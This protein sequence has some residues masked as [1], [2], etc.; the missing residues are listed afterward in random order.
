[1]IGRGTLGRRILA[2][3]GSVA[4]LAGLS[5]FVLTRPVATRQGVNYEVSEH[6]V[7][8]YLK[9]TDFMNRS[10]QYRQIA[11]E[12]AGAL[13]SDES[14][15][16]AVFEW[17]RRNVRPTP[18]GFPVVDDH[19]LN[20]VT[21]GYGMPDQRADVFATLATYAGVPAFWQTLRLSASDGGL[22]LTFVLIDGRWRV[23]DVGAGLA[24]RNERN[25]LATLDD[26]RRQ[27]ECVPA[28]LRDVVIGTI[29][30]GDRLARA[31]M[32][33][34]PDPLRAELQMPVVRLWHEMKVALHLERDEDAE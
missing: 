27:P 13:P 11:E 12:V 23:F 20:I 6:R 30:Y 9:A 3:R 28:S 31:T 21:R 26:L 25:E 17:T 14:R 24:F 8:L 16:L 19:I 18:D 4:A 29:T 33:Q 5:L 32:P 2:A 22:I 34:I 15:A 1:M 10:V 7:P